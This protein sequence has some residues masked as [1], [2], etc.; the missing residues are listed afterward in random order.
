MMATV[1]RQRIVFPILLLALMSACT[2]ASTTSEPDSPSGS[3]SKPEPEPPKH[4]PSV[5][6]DPVLPAAPTFASGPFE[7]CGDGAKCQPLPPS[8]AFGFED[9]PD[10]QHHAW[11]LG[12]TADGSA[13]AYC[14][15]SPP[16]CEKCIFTKPDGEVEQLATRDCGGQGTRVSS[17]QLKQ[18]VAER[19][20]A[21]RDGDWAHGGELVITNRTIEGKP[22]SLG[23]PRATL[24]VGTARRDGSAAGD[25]YRE[26]ACFQASGETSC[27]SIAHA[28]AIVPSPDG[29]WVAILGHMWFGEWS[30][31]FVVELM[32]AGRLAA[33]TYNRQGLDALAREDFEAA[34]TAFAAVM[35]ADPTAWKG[36][37]NLACAYARAADPRAQLAL[38]VAVERGG[39]AVREKAVKDADLDA[40]RSQAWFTALIGAAG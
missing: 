38:Q 34:A 29:T 9:G 4:T 17:K 36:P 25:A 2:S 13:F 31:T 27:F 22:D 11:A 32:P 37:Y 24:E 23:E 30:D 5:E 21:L 33:A 20:V 3:A 26:D 8:R 16:E 14:E 15:F 35:H 28:D 39:D 6:T 18:R 1:L 12:W 10:M 19:G 40:V 7:V